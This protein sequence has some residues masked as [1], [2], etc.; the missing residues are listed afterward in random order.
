M[1]LVCTIDAT[2]IHKPD[3]ADVLADLQAAYRGIYGADIYIEPDSQDG[4]LLA[5][6]AA[7]L[8]DANAMAVAVY[9]A[10]SPQ[11][12]QGVGLSTVVKINGIKR[13]VASYSTVDVTLTGQAGTTIA[14]G[15]VADA[16]GNQWALPASVT[17]PSGGAVTATATARTIGAVLAPAN[18]VT[19]I[20]TPTRGWQSVTNPSAATAGSPVE[21]DSALRQR[22]AVS[23]AIPSLTVLEGIIGAV[24]SVPGVVRYR[25]YEND[26]DVTDANGITSHSI[27]LVVDGGDSTLIAQ[28]IAAKKAPGSGTYGTT[29]VTVTDAYGIPHAVKFFR[30]TTQT[31]KVNISLT[32]MAGYTTAVEAQIKQAVTDYVNGLRIGESVEWA[33][34]FVPANLALAGGSKTYKITAMTIAKG[35]GA[36]GTADIAIAFNEAAT[37]A[38]SDISITVV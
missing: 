10:F 32:A 3:Y 9:N 17:I 12:A 7:A 22:Q 26:S 5:I 4:Q 24:A 31:I 2:G 21:T 38:L 23:T 16:S 18:T 1:A 8:N 34:V 29:S 11:T 33:E 27:S 25:A 28:E 19:Q 20:V 30:P 15:I 14:G 36:P 6:F 13:A 35:A 37:A